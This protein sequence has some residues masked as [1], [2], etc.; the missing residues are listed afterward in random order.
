[1]NDYPDKPRDKLSDADK[2]AVQSAIDAV[3]EAKK[4][5][6][7]AALNTAIDNLGRAS[8]AACS[9]SGLWPSPSSHL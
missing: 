3:N 6:D 9:L 5:D 8:Q 4:H 1:M 2:Q 7:L